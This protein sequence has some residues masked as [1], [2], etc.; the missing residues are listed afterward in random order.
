[1]P[2]RTSSSCSVRGA[3]KKFNELKYMTDIPHKVSTGNKFVDK[4]VAKY[5]VKIANGLVKSPKGRIVVKVAEKAYPYVEKGGAN[6]ARAKAA[7]NSVC[8]GKK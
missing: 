2:K 1:M 7:F 3:I 6:I 8:S 4:T 5:G